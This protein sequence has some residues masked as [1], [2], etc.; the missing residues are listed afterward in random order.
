[1]VVAE[2]VMMAVVVVAAQSVTMEVGLVVAMQ[3]VMM[4]V[5]ALQIRICSIHD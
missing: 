3:G 1:M 5:E 2:R 4:E